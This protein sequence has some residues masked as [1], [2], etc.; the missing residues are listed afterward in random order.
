M[1]GIAAWFFAVLHRELPSI[2]RMFAGG[3]LVLVGLLIVLVRNWL[4]ALVSKQWGVE[5]KAGAFLYLEFGVLIV[6]GGC[7]LIF[8]PS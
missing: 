2:D 1:F 8:R 5:K 6:V 7:T 3:S 4:G